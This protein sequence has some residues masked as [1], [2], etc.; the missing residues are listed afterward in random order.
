M[1][2]KKSAKTLHLHKKGPT[3]SKF[4]TKK[5]SRVQALSVE[6]VHIDRDCQTGYEAVSP[7]SHGVSHGSIGEVAEWLKA[8]LS[9]S[10]ILSK[11]GSWVR[12][13]PSP[14]KKDSLTGFKPSSGCGIHDLLLIKNDP[15]GPLT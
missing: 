4:D 13:P 1:N 8:P 5:K 15:S 14:P 2:H 9:K 6:S 10:G 3:E 7:G 12:I 11:T